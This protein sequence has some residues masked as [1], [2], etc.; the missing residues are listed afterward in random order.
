MDALA[1]E[2]LLSVEILGLE[3]PVG[4]TWRNLTV[5]GVQNRTAGG[6]HLGDHEGNGL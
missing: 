5:V 4:A 3:R 1:F 6:R 2:D